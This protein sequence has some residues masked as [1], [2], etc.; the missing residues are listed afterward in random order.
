MSKNLP[1]TFRKTEKNQLLGVTLKNRWICFKK[2][3]LDLIGVAEGLSQAAP[4]VPSPPAS[5]RRWSWL[6]FSRF[7]QPGKRLQ[8]KRFGL[9]CWL[10]KKIFM[11]FIMIMICRC[12]FLYLHGGSSLFRLTDSIRVNQSLPNQARASKEVMN[13]SSPRKNTWRNYCA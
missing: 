9:G 12:R 4:W 2:N 6:F 3:S 13:L 5:R 10:N 1:P 8:E 7:V 11:P